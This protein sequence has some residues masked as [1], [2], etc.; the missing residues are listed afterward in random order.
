MKKFTKT[1]LAAAVLSASTVA[2]AEISANVGFVSEYYFRGVNLGDAGAYA[3]ADFEHSGFYAGVWAIDDSDD[4][5]S[6]LETDFYLG[7]GT[8]FSGVS[9]GLGYTRFEYTNSGDFEH[10]INFT[11]GYQGFGF[12]YT[13]GEDDDEGEDE[14]DYDFIALSWSGEVFGATYG[15]YE[16]DDTDDEYDYFELSASGEVAGLDASLTLGQR[17]N[18]KNASGD[19]ESDDAYLFIDISKSFDL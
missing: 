9:V 2:Q 11:L 16:N 17:T 15:S 14:T 12:E 18:I 6:G 7:Y 5:N 1:I 8:E 3:G 13:T 19:V 4:G 10:E